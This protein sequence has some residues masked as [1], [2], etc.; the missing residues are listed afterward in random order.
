MYLSTSTPRQSTE[1]LADKRGLPS[2]IRLLPRAELLFT[3]TVLGVLGVVEP[4]TYQRLLL[5]LQ[6]SSGFLTCLGPNHRTTKVRTVVRSKPLLSELA[7]RLIVTL[8]ELQELSTWLLGRFS[9]SRKR[10]S[11]EQQV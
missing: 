6:A 7:V 11:A 3:D 5:T 8:V 9:H 1:L 4:V 2:R 10:L